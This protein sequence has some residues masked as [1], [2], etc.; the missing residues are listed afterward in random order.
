[1]L[2]RSFAVGP[3]GILKVLK[4]ADEP[5]RGALQRFV[6]IDV[7]E[8]GVV[9]ERKQDVTELI[10]DPLLIWLWGLQL[11]AQ[12]PQLLFHLV[13]NLSVHCPNQTPRR[14]PCL[15]RGTP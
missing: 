4:A 11:L 1:M 5:A 15:A 13:P 12:L 6:W 9:D 10:G 3:D 2:V 8:P 7:H 14:A